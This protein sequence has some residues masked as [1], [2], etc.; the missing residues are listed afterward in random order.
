MNTT[1]YSYLSYNQIAMKID[2]MVPAIREA[3]FDALVVIVRGGSFPGTHLSIRTG[4]PIYFLSY[5]RKKNPPVVNWIGE[6]A[7]P[8]KLLL[9]EDVA[10]AGK[11]LSSCL[12]FLLLSSYEVNTFVVFKDTKSAVEPDFFCFASDIPDRTFLLPW[13]KS[14]INPSY[15]TLDKSERF[16]DHELEFTVWNMNCFVEQDEMNHFVK[17]SITPIPLLE[18]NDAILTTES[19]FE[20]IHRK[21]LKG[22]KVSH[23]FYVAE[24]DSSFGSHL[25]S[26]ILVGNQLMTI[27]CTRYV[28]NDVENLVLLS[29]CFPHLEILWWNSGNPIALTT[30]HV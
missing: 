29:S 27:G 5:E 8:G 13:E 1:R 15:L 17:R 10:G 14:K 11:T 2:T 16:V 21:W 3:S 28:D 24:P 9:V 19:E 6:P 30:S 26:A 4:L 7:P 20:D 12:H 25:G 18:E 22:N 23:P